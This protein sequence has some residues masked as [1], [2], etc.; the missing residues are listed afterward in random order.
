[1]WSASRRQTLRAKRSSG[2]TGLE[3]AEDRVC[4]GEESA[5]DR[6]CY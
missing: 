4:Y 5:F 1:M 3:C 6:D 2:E